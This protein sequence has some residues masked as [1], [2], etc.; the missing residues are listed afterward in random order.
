MAEPKPIFDCAICDEPAKYV[1]VEGKEGVF[2]RCSGGCGIVRGWQKANQ[3]IVAQGAENIRA[4][5]KQRLDDVRRE[6][7][8]MLDSYALCDIFKGIPV[9]VWHS[10][11]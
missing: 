8:P 4:N 7:A 10:G 3:L 2:L 9:F 1:N 5:I 6:D 11:D